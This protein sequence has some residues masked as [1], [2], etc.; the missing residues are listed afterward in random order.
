M[1]TAGFRYFLIRMIY[2]LF[3]KFT[4]WDYASAISF[5]SFGKHRLGIAGAFFLPVSRNV[6]MKFPPGQFS[7]CGELN[8]RGLCGVICRRNVL[9]NGRCRCGHFPYGRLAGL[10][11]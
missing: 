2:L 1:D 7:C 3:I 8:G 10:C 9:C 11:R 4:G 6:K 5:Y